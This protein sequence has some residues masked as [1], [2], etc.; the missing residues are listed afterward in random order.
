MPTSAD[1]DAMDAAS[2]ERVARKV[3]LLQKTGFDSTVY[4]VDGVVT[5]AE[6]A[7][8]IAPTSIEGIEI[9]KTQDARGLISIRTKQGPVT[10]VT[11]DPKADREAQEVRQNKLAAVG[12]SIAITY[13]PL[14][15]A[16]AKGDPLVY[17]DGVKSTKSAI[18]AL[19]KQDI[20]SVEVL[21]GTAAAAYVKDPAAEYGVIF[22]KTKKGGS[23]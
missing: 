22:I 21:K 4:L 8:A 16:L 23:K 19:N 15:T 9:K 13:R 18:G 12:D 11:M 5:T 2:A 7:N 1:V 14:K 17:I 20:E 6:K 3:T 10:M